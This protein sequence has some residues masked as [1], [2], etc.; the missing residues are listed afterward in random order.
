MRLQVVE[1]GSYVGRSGLVRA[2]APASGAPRDAHATIHALLSAQVGVV[3]AFAL[4]EIRGRHGL[5]TH[6]LA[7]TKVPSIV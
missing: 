4:P 5:R 2:C 1:C 6:R 7:P 3:G